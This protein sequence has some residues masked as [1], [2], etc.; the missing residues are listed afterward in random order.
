MNNDLRYTG[1]DIMLQRAISQ[2]KYVPR[3]RRVE[4]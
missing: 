2:L 4:M 3:L 1:I